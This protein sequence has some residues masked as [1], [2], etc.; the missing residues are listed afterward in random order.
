MTTNSV[1]SS[2]LKIPPT[3]PGLPI[4]G[5]TLAF[6]N[7]EG[8]PVE[9]FRLAAQQL[10]DIV[11]LRAAGRTI[12]LVSHPALIQEI[13]VKRVQDFHKPIVLSKRPRG[14]DRFFARGILTSDYPEW[15]PQRKVIQPLMHTKH[16]ESYADTMVRFGETLLSGWRDGEARDIHADMTRVTI[17]I[18]TETMFGMDMAHTPELAMAGRLAQE[19]TLADV[20]LPLPEWLMWNRNRKASKANDVMSR[21]VARLMHERRTNPQSETRTDLLTLLMQTR[22]DENN[23]MPDQ[24]VRDNI[25]TLFFAGHETTANTLVWALH[26]LDRN[27]DVLKRLQAE[28]DSVLQGRAPTLADLRNL[29]YTLMVIKETMRIEPTAPII[30][31]ALVEDVELDGYLLEKDSMVFIPPYVVHH[32]TRWWSRPDA[33]DPNRFSEMNEPE[34]P[35]YAYLPFGGGPRVCI[36]NHFSL[37]EAQILLAMIVSRYELSHTHDTTVIRL[38]HV[39]T[40]PKDGLTMTVRTRGSVI[41]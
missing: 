5:N 20:T 28:V 32:D 30:P 24:F 7:Q 4:L 12:Y 23:P 14:L 11:R 31:R 1:S 16:V 8:L 41:R 10:G 13:L 39:T 33:F 27:P 9:A 34:I 36:G 26:Y 37:M 21:L 15:R 19:V 17:W 3:M 35:K 38:R 25:L 22:D 29:P 18:I 40:Y 6:T 2:P